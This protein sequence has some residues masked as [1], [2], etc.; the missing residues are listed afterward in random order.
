MDLEAL[1]NLGDFIGGLAVIVT[2][3]YLAAQ[4]RQNTESV[5][6][7]SRLEIA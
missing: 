1:G 4:I 7:A 3:L 2:F 6:A 5:R